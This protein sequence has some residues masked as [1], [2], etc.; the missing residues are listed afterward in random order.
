MAIDNGFSTTMDV[1]NSLNACGEQETS[2]RLF[3]ES[4]ELSTAAPFSGADSEAQCASLLGLPELELVAANSDV[5][6]TQFCSAEVNNR[7]RTAEQLRRFL[8]G[9]AFDRGGRLTEE[10]VDGLIHF[11][12]RGSGWTRQGRIQLLQDML[13][14]GRHNVAIQA[15]DGAY[16]LGT[17]GTY[18]VDYTPG[19]YQ[20]SESAHSPWVPSSIN[21]TFT[22]GG[23]LS[24][25][26]PRR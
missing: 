20:H 16:P 15:A 5:T 24:T 21:L 12:E 11:I 6:D 8:N 19:Y 3:S 14:A 25:L 2:V 7:P 4:C 9:S 26:M 10:G 23:V 18:R 17:R 1:D 22:R 13:N